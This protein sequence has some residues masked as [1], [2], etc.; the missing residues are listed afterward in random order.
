MNK[1]NLI[2][3]A[4]AVL[5]RIKSIE[6][7]PAKQKQLSNPDSFFYQHSDSSFTDYQLTL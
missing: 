2:L 5:N 4:E 3:K 6:T 7:K 1:N